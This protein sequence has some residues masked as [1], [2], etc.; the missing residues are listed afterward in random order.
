M[1]K[2]IYY[3]VD[4]RRKLKNGVDKLG[5]A[6][7]VTLGAKGRNVIIQGDYSAPHVTK[8]GVTVARSISLPDAVENMGAE[9][10]KEVAAKVVD[11]AGDG[12]TTAT[13]LAQAIISEGVEVIDSHRTPWWMFWNKKNR[14]VNPM[15]LKRGIDKGVEV[16]TRFLDAMSEKVS[17]DSERIKQIAT[18]SANNDESIGEIIAEA[19]AKVSNEGSISVEEAKGNETYVEVVEGLEFVSGLL[20]PY[21]VTNPEKATAEFD[22]PLIF[23]YGGKIPNTKMILPVIELGLQS[24]RPLLIIADDFEGEVIA[25]LAKNRVQKGFQIAA[26]KSPS[27]G[28]NRKNTMEDIAL[29]TGG[30]VLNEEKGIE[31]KDF[32]KEMFGESEKTVITRENTTIIGGYGDKEEIQNRIK[33]L[34]AQIEE[35]KQEFDDEILKKRIAKLVGGVAVIYVG[36]NTE[37]EVKERR[38]RID[39]SLSATRAAVEEGIVAGG[40]IALL[41]CLGALLNTKVDNEDQLKGVDILFKAIQEPARQI[42]QNSGLNGMEVVKECLE[43]EYPMGY[44]SKED[45]YENMIN[46]G[47]I[48]PKK[49]TRV[50]LESAASIASLL[51]TTEAT[52]SNI[53]QN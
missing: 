32:T 20:S 1:S 50:A 4:A 16:V 28:E 36:G 8:D 11:L 48:D 35:S 5:N 29:V 21:F 6:V 3:D 49:V 7:K 33:Q 53:K 9:M 51:L 44:N 15:D 38:D 10:V 12:T 47:I 2:E 22:N 23:L 34:K 30:T 42:A 27:F 43:L 39:D 13:I 31:I 46:A 17:H 19:M 40:G 52:I 25:T 24:G 14:A 45:R 26:V 37:V 18:I 41:A